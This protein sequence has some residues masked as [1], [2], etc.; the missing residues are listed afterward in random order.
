[1][2]LK[3]RFLHTAGHVARSKSRT[4]ALLAGV[5]LAG[6]A[7]V[8]GAAETVDGFTGPLFGLTWDETATCSSPIPPRA[9]WLSGAERPSSTLRCPA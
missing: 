3:A 5:A 7:A 8:T 1:M 2:C 9:S 4:I 6:T